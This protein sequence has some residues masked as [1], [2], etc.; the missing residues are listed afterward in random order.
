[1]T[2]YTILPGK[3][4][5]FIS[6]MLLTS[7]LSTQAGNTTTTQSPQTD[8]PVVLQINE[9]SAAFGS[10]I[11]T[12]GDV[13]GDGYDDILVGAGMFSG[14]YT[15]EGAAFLYLG[16]ASGL[17][18]KP[19]W[20]ITGGQNA[21]T[22]GQSV[23]TAG[24][25]NDDGYDDIL[26]SAPLYDVAG[27][28]N[29][30]IVYVF[31]GSAAGLSSIPA[32][33]LS[34]DKAS[35]RFGASIAGGTDVNGDGYSDIIIG[36]YVDD[37]QTGNDGIYIYH[38]GP[39]GLASIPAAILRFSQPNTYFGNTVATAGDINADGYDDI[40]AGA[41]YYDGDKVNE[42]AVVLYAGSPTG[43]Q[44][45]P[46]QQFEGNQPGALF[47]LSISTAGDVNNDGYDD[48]VIG[49]YGSGQDGAV[50]IY[51]GGGTGMQLTTILKSNQTGALFG[52]SVS[53]AGDV[54]HDSFS[55]I[56]V[57]AP[58]YTHNEENEGAVLLYL[59]GPSGITDIPARIH[60]SNSIFAEYGNRVTSPG[61]NNGDGYDDYLAG[62]FKYTQGEYR[63]GA[64]FFYPGG[65][66]TLPVHLLTF[67][68][69]AEG[70]NAI[71]HWEAGTEDNLTHYTVEASTDGTHFTPVDN[72]PRNA[73][74]EY[75][76]TTHQQMPRTYYR[77]TGA[78]INGQL[79]HSRLTLVQT[80]CVESSQDASVTLYPNPA[81]SKVLI[82][83]LTRAETLRI[84]VYDP[85][86]PAVVQYTIQ[87]F[88]PSNSMLACYRPGSIPYRYSKN[89][90][91]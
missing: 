68:G 5:V 12:A 59:G 3:Y 66:G 11:A 44:Q 16:S 10:S 54:N 80:E 89:Q 8:G 67:S 21:A 86:R 28:A 91:P 13:N 50:W 77:I 34:L 35:T 82:S 45:T 30:G 29:A 26:V 63:E 20:Q 19:A 85:L 75:T 53:K 65:T 23:A 7:S 39:S 6:T 17:N 58:M 61:D 74:G 87:P 24:D 38:G 32:W 69:R 49:G 79:S 25:I 62:A 36:A 55:D 46:L 22:L 33:Q 51:Q 18:A 70:C 90:F 56:I 41:P 88:S 81:N 84:T 64:V 76:C 57:G 48:I 15:N 14:S 72:I 1:M 42:G 60:E 2:L 4:R 43:I 78:D 83:N 40:L 47:G 73:T 31:T 9:V 52:F 27:Q 37:G 71:L